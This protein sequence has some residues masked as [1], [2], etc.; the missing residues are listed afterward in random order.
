MRKL[1]VAL[2]IVGLLFSP[3]VPSFY[4]DGGDYLLPPVGTAYADNSR[5]AT[6]TVA[7]SY[8]YAGRFN[9]RGLYDISSP[10]RHDTSLEGRLQYMALR[11]VAGEYH[12]EYPNWLDYPKSVQPSDLQGWRCQW[13]PG[14][15]E[16]P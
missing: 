11:D 7:C 6:S 4:G 8:S 10:M 13:W 12:K 15:H 1:L 5:E 9:T 2:A 16:I 14:Y 3:I